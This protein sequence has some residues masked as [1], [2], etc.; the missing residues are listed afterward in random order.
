MVRFRT[1]AGQVVQKLSQQYVLTGDAKDVGRRRKGEILF[2][3]EPELRP[4]PTSSKR[5]YTTRSREGQRPCRHVVV[6]GPDSP[7]LRM[8]SLVLVLA[9]SRRRRSPEGRSETAPPFYYGD[10]LLYPNVGEPLQRGTGRSLSFY[11]VVYPV[12]GRCACTARISLLRNGQPIAEAH[13]A[14]CETGD[15]AAAARRQ[16]ADC[17]LPAG[18]YELRVTVTDSQDQ[19]TRTAFFTVKDGGASGLEWVVDSGS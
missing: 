5:S 4:A 13:A 17:E 14:S 11:F 8:S 7:R 12:P 9:P 1:G 16:P 2:Y 15:D 18:T 6:P 3:R 10:T 19:Q